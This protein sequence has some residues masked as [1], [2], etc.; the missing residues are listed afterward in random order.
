MSNFLEDWF[1]VEDLAA[2]AA[3]AI[4][5]AMP[6]DKPALSRAL[7]EIELRMQQYFARRAETAEDELSRRRAE[8]RKRGV[9]E[10][11]ADGADL[12]ADLAN[13]DTRR[14]S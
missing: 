14:P 7:Q 6:V 4:V 2:E 1:L 10:L 13:D 3:L 9:E 5:N 12:H 11:M 8:I